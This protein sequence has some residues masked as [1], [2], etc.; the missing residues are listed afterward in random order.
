[1]PEPST[2]MEVVGI[3]DVPPYSASTTATPTPIQTNS[4][5]V[6]QS[7]PF[8]VSPQSYSEKPRSRIPDMTLEN[9]Y[10]ALDYYMRKPQ[11]LANPRTKHAAE[12]H[13]AAATKIVG[14]SV[15]MEAVNAKVDIANFRL[16]TD[17]RLVSDLNKGV[18][19]LENLEVVSA[20]TREVEEN[21][22]S[23]LAISMMNSQL[24]KEAEER[25]KTATA[26]KTDG[27]IISGD[28]RHENR[29]EEI[30]ASKKGRDSNTFEVR[31]YDGH[32]FLTGSGFKPIP[33][34]SLTPENK[35]EAQVAMETLRSLRKMTEDATDPTEKKNLIQ[36]Q[37]NVLSTLREI[38][39]GGPPSTA[40]ATNAPA[41][42]TDKIRVTKPDGTTGWIPASQK[43]AALQQG[44]KLIP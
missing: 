18:A 32:K 22:P 39:G 28:A 31:E 25:A 8:Q 36:R 23:P 33:L 14:M 40:P 2:N 24:R 7:V 20:I 44:F 42:S 37:Q 35:I 5:S 19:K 17:R 15:Q 9:A 3:D 11:W 29:M 10:H 21:G 38:T 1:M 6:R 13:L 43:D 26:I 12:A 27:Q 30:E 16:S 41:A 34:N 4:P